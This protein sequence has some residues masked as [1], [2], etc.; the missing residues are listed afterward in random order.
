MTTRGRIPFIVLVLALFVGGMVLDRDRP[1]ARSVDSAAD[2]SRS[3]PLAASAEALGSVWFCAAGSSTPD[4][5]A[6]HTVVIANP[7]DHDRQV[8]LTAFPGTADPVDTAIP[9][10][11]NSVE[12]VR[13]AELVEAPAVAAMVEALA[14]EI[15]VTHELVGSQGRDTGPCASSTSDIWH[16]A[17]GDTSRD[18]T[19]AVALFNPFPGDAVVDFEF[20]TIDGSRRPTALT[21]VVVPGRSVVVSD[22]A[23]EIARRDQVSATVT[24]RSGRVVAE[25]VHTFDDSEELLEGSIPRRG[26]T[27]DLGAPVPMT[28]WVFPSVRFTDGLH[29]RMVVF[30]PTGSTAEVDVEV[31]LADARGGGVA[32]FE[33][34]V[35]AGA[36]EVIDLAAETRIS[37]LT[38]EGPV[39]ATLV[40]R[41][42][43]DVG[44]V[45]ERITTVP[46]T[47]EGPGVV[48]S[49]GVP[50][51]GRVLTL[52]DARP[53]R[54]EG[55]SLTLANPDG[56]TLVTGT[57]HV[58]ARGT[59]RPLEGFASFELSPGGRTTVDITERVTGAGVSALL[60]ESS[61]P[62]V[63]A[64]LARST[65]PSDR[66]AV[67]AIGRVGTVSPPP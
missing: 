54:A 16:F 51:A 13:L 67:E 26:L 44:V 3:T 59:R 41:S 33:L 1:S 9:V 38:V 20:V 63:A 49:S 50:L 35:R 7:T 2:I 22:V 55:V 5:P 62:I 4:G 40:V 58:V 45:A 56:N 12:R 10:P 17:W 23:A 64:T 65:D 60:I 25:R 37:D 24:V 8:T 36:Y 6:D 42:L 43:N 11:A 18:A 39:E 19:T 29:E 32:P 21:G 14:G 61:Q 66:L 27:V 53:G 34:T 46:T 31:L 15:V 57:V 28:T 52:V 47:A 48:A 30:N